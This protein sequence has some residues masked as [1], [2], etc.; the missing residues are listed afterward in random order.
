MEGV[1]DEPISA[2]DMALVDQDVAAAEASGQPLTAAELREKIKEI[3]KMKEELAR[4]EDL[5]KEIRRR[6]DGK[7]MLEVARKNAELKQKLE[8]EQQRKQREADVQYKKRLL[9][10][11]ERDKERRK[12]ARNPAAVQPQTAPAKPLPTVN[13]DE[14]RICF[15]FS[16]GKRINAVFPSSAKFQEVYDHV[17]KNKLFDGNYELHRTYPRAPIKDFDKNLIELQLTPAS[18]LAVSKLT[19][20]Q[21]LVLSRTQEIVK[22]IF[23]LLLTIISCPLVTARDFI[24]SLFGNNHVRRTD[25]ETGSNRMV[26]QRKKKERKDHDS[27]DEGTW[28]GNSTQQL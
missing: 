5:E 25:G 11:L 3:K 23:Y 27:D 8:L 10:E 1:N 16:D 9:E 19:T 7:A 21:A 6:E 18:V 22:S 20:T 2:A 24:V 15:Q 17:A 28:N 14:C 13:S 12:A 26:E 4:K